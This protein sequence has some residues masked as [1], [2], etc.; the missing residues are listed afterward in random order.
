MFSEFLLELITS[1]TVSAVLTAILIWL[2]K[3]TV[4][5]RLKNAIK[6]EYDQKLETHKSKLKART[7]AGIETHKAQLKSQMD[8]EIE[9]LKSSLSIAAAER[10]IKFSK[11][12][13]KRASVIAE[14]YSLLNELYRAVDNYVKVFEPAGGKPRKERCKIAV[15]A[16]QALRKYYSK[17]IIFLPQSMVEKI[18]KID[19]ELAKTFLEFANDIDSQEGTGNTKQWYKIFERMKGEIKDAFGELENE[20]RKLLGDDS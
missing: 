18:R 2:F 10:N 14:T 11:L 12:H 15:K 1:A 19:I 17:R 16:L 20:F 6:N 4:S 13:E 9:K 3:T 5:E 8:V 7:D